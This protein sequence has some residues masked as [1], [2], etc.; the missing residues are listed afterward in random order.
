LAASRK[1]EILRFH[2]PTG[3][4]ENTEQSQIPSVRVGYSFALRTLAQGFIVA[5]STDTTA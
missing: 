2:P 4:C 1:G 3:Y 5:S